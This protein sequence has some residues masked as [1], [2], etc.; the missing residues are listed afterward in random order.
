MRR[1]QAAAQCL[2]AATGNG[3]WQMPRHAAVNVALGC[4]RRAAAGWVRP[5]VGDGRPDGAAYAASK[6]AAVAQ[7]VATAGAFA[8]ALDGLTVRVPHAVRATRAWHAPPPAGA[9]Y[10]PTKGRYT[11]AAGNGMTSRAATAH[12]RE[13]AQGLSALRPPPA[14]TPESVAA[15]ETVR[16][17]DAAAVLA[18]S[19]QW[20][21]SRR[22]SRYRVA[23]GD[24]ATAGQ[25]KARVHQVIQRRR[26]DEAVA[27][28]LTGG[29]LRRVVNRSAVVPVVGQAATQGGATWLRRHLRRLCWIVNADE[30]NSSQACAGCRHQL[31]IVYASAA[32]PPCVPRGTMI[33]GRRGGSRGRQGPPRAPP[34]AGWERTQ[35][36]CSATGRAAC[37]TEG[38]KLA[39]ERAAKHAPPTGVV[40]RAPA[41]AGVWG[42][43]RCVE[44][45]CPQMLVIR[46][47]NAAANMGWKALQ[48]IRQLPCHPFRFVSRGSGI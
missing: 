22:Q 4:L 34:T 15:H 20:M 43:K 31:A 28:E 6:T 8:S 38:A 11:E 1:L 30:H 3:R 18:S 26:L 37:R 47:V 2:V 27:R 41:A 42:V 29:R 21:E 23:W 39:A 48:Q 35:P 13:A 46:D 19:R 10:T 17:G 33:S 14:T 25:R 44:R 40:F 45:T 36:V 16:T 7:D 9:V 32:S 24:A 12:R 5:L